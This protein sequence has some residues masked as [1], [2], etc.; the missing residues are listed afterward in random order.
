MMIKILASGGKEIF[1]D[2]FLVKFEMTVRLTKGII[3][4]DVPFYEL[5]RLKIIIRLFE[6][7]YLT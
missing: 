4:L 5:I 6:P 2:V 7:I 1:L 3:F